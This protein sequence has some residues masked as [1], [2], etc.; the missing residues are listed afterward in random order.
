M[1]LDAALPR[2]APLPE[3]ERL[4]AAFNALAALRTP[5]VEAAVPPPPAPP[6]ESEELPP[7]TAELLLTVPVAEEPEELPDGEP[8]P[9]EELEPELEDDAPPPP[10]RLP[11]NA[12]LPPEKLR[13]PRSRGPVMVT[14]FSGAVVPVSRM[15]R[16][17]VPAATFAVRTLATMARFAA[18]ASSAS[19]R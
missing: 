12:P 2:E 15:V 8:P 10:P 17:S 5:P 4:V 16:V 19:V 7:N 3:D 18:T 1:E 14:Y 9:G 6:A 13:L 11:M